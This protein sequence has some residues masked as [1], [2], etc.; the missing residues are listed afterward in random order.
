MN[1]IRDSVKLFDPFFSKCLYADKSRI[2][3][4]VDNNVIL[5][6][7]FEHKFHKTYINT[8]K[9]K[10]NFSIKNWPNK[11]F[12]ETDRFEV[13]NFSHFCNEFAIHITKK[14]GFWMKK[15]FSVKNHYLSKIFA[16]ESQYTL[17][18]KIL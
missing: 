11:I 1:S 3:N 9:T 12:K 4:K 2:L 13:Q 15:L 14:L 7:L 10:R 6:N 8:K 16:F 18:N 5:S 17:Y